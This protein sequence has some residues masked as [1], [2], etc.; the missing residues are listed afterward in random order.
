MSNHQT[1]DCLLN[2]LFRLRSKKISNFASLAFVRGIHRWA[3]NYPHKGPVTGKNVSNWWRHN[4]TKYVLSLPVH[5][6][7]WSPGH[8]Q[9]WQFSME[10]GCD[11]LVTRLKN[12]D[13]NHVFPLTGFKMIQFLHYY[14]F[15]RG[16][17]VHEL[18]NKHTR[19]SRD[20][21]VMFHVIC[22]YFDCPFI[23]PI[24]LIF[25]NFISWFMHQEWLPSL[26][27]VRYFTYRL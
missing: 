20:T 8:Q 19:L 18:F 22:L 26:S 25:S 3:V 14:P 13:S 1:H 2:S 12:I 7:L 4:E 15:V 23:I 21:A 5:N 9:P 27:V 10:E 17:L 11:Y 6:L 16:M 24:I